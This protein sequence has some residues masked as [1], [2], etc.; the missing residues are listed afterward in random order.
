MKRRLISMAEVMR[1]ERLGRR[2]SLQCQTRI[3]ARRTSVAA[4]VT[5]QRVTKVWFAKEKKQAN[6]VSWKLK[7]EGRGERPTFKPIR[8]ARVLKV[9]SP[10][11]EPI[12]P[13]S[14]W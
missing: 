13:A 10:M 3:P 4:E 12:A 8:S 2:K 14:Y 7:L 6:Q 5:S 11:A 1:D 9:E